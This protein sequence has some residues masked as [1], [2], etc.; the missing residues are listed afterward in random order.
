MNSPKVSLSTN[1]IEFGRFVK[2]VTRKKPID[3]YQLVLICRI[4]LSLVTIGLI[5]YALDRA[6][7]SSITR[8]K[9]I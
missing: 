5:G 1:A 3:F 8:I 4:M 2:G 7:L 6:R 9:R